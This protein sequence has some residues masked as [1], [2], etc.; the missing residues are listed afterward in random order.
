MIGQQR[1]IRISI[2]VWN[3]KQKFPDIKAEFYQKFFKKG[4]LLLPERYN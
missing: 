4:H 2:W 3:F 1:K